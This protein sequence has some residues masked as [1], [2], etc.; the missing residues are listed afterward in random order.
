[1]TESYE[2]FQERRNMAYTES[3]G[4]RRAAIQ[5]VLTEEAKRAPMLEVAPAKAQDAVPIQQPKKRYYPERARSI[6]KRLPEADFMRS[7]PCVYCGGS[8]EHFD[9]IQALTRGGVHDVDNLAPSCWR[10][11]KHKGVRPFL[12]YLIYRRWFRLGKVSTDP[13]NADTVE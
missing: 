1:M 2:Q 8:F 9:H 7:D 4:R 6:R 10:C 13:Q 3:I 5:K 11:N 12:Q